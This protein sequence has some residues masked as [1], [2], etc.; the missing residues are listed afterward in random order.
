MHGIKE[1]EA[2]AMLS[3]SDE[4]RGIIKERFA[5]LAE[6]LTAVAAVDTRDI[7]PLVSVLGTYNI[8]REDTSEQIIPRDE[9]LNNAPEQYDG[10]F[11]VPGTLE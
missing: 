11:Q 3:L 4:E 10:Y 9:L 6:N 2:M 7:K 5:E 8:L 1:Y